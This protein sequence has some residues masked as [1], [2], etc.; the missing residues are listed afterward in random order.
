MQLPSF[1]VQLHS[2]YIAF[3]TLNSFI[4]II[5]IFHTRDFS[6]L[7]ICFSLVKIKMLPF[8]MAVHKFLWQD[9][10]HSKS[11]CFLALWLLLCTLY[12]PL[13]LLGWSRGFDPGFSWQWKILRFVRF[14]QHLSLSVCLIIWM[15]IK[16]SLL[17]FVY[18]FFC[19]RLHC[20]ISDRNGS[21][22]RLCFLWFVDRLDGWW[23][24]VMNFLRYSWSLSLDQLLTL[25]H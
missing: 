12:Q 1:W 17:S 5:M 8:L 20:R 25:R 22:F 11:W 9:A 19:T 6:R 23:T 21:N 24:I 13:R 7:Q 15:L 18:N 14:C 2:G 10:C 3:Q 16:R 4:N